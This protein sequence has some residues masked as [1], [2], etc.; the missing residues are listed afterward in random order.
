MLF[1]NLSLVNQTKPKQE[2]VL[3]SKA[4]S[5]SQTPPSGGGFAYCI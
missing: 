1:C 4:A 3:F 2:D 5:S